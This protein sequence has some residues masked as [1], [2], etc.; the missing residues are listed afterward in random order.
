M[1]C[2]QSNRAHEIRVKGNEIKVLKFSVASLNVEIDCLYGNA[3]RD[4]KPYHNMFD[5][6]DI[7]ISVSQEDIDREL[8]K[9]PEIMNP[10]VTVDDER[11]A[12][13]YD[14]GCLEPFV[15]LPKLAD[16]VVL[17]ETL[18]M[19]GAV[20]EKEG[21]AYMFTAPSGTG[22]TTRLRLWL[23]QYPDSTI[24]NGDKP[25][26]RIDSEK[27]YAYG[28]PWSGKEG[29]NTNTN[30]P[31]QAIFI[32]ERAEKD[33]IEEISLGKAFPVLLQQTHCPLNPDLMRK[34]I[35]LLMSFEGRVKIYRYQSTLDPETVKLAFETAKP[36]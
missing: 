18:L 17:F 21:Y 28:T 22:K 31:L 30:A 1:N 35:R 33:H 13:T 8:L 16:Q 7:L 11:V 4:F 27:V 24:I 6:P 34:T 10:N 36:R 20:I 9:H 32:L 23:N 29:W 5:K 2:V 14:Y 3:F 12:V 19:H 15:A 26:I 25:L